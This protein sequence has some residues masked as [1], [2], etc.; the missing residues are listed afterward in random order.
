MSG[1][2]SAS[3]LVRDNVSGPTES[4]S[5]RSKLNHPAASAHCKSDLWIQIWLEFG[6]TGMTFSYFDRLWRPAV[7]TL[8]CVSAFYWITALVCSICLNRESRGWKTEALLKFALISF[9]ALHVCKQQM[10]SDLFVFHFR[11][12]FCI[13]YLVILAILYTFVIWN[14]WSCS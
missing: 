11:R 14:W 10:I 1:R 4:R 3:A 7:F 2:P 6:G 8:G 5:V 13:R 12:C 9:T